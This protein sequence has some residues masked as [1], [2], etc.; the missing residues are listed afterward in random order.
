MKIKT[1]LL[2]FI[3]FLVLPHFPLAMPEE[4]DST[5]NHICVVLITGIGCSTCAKIESLI[6]VELTSQI[7]E[8]VVLKYEIYK[9][10]KSNHPVFEQYASSYLSPRE[11]RVIPFLILNR[12]KYF[13]GE[14]E[15]RKGIQ[16]I[17]ETSEN[18]CPLPDGNLASW[19]FLNPDTL[20]GEVKIFT[21]NRV[22]ISKPDINEKT[23]PDTAEIC[24]KEL[25]SAKD[26]DSAMKNMD[27]KE[28]EPEPVYI[29][30]RKISFQKAVE[31]GKWK[32]QW[33]G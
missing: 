28:T 14:M 31:V 29:S 3:V 20:P 1:I 26:V 9:S 27:F 12:E 19:T 33:N 30:G 4:S 15:T 5:K 7:P 22:F 24:I 32:L 11:P 21:K 18:M 16:A 6:L 2:F 8:L 17:R 23:I 25:V 10:H 13:R